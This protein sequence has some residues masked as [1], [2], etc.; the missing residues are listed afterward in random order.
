MDSE[1]QV[2]E[3]LMGQGSRQSSGGSGDGSDLMD[4]KDVDRM[5]IVGWI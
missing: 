1:V 2:V 5:A 3:S 4:Y